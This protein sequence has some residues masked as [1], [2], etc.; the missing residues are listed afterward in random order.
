M[1]DGVSAWRAYG[2]NASDFSRDL[3]L[4]AK[5]EIDT[6]AYAHGSLT[7]KRKSNSMHKDF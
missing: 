3:M 7:P 4:Y 5:N 1:A 6:P 2:L